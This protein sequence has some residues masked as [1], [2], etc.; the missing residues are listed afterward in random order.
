M[1]EKDRQT[2]IEE[3][4]A[5]LDDLE[6]QLKQSGEDVKGTYQEKKKRIANILRQYAKQ[7]EEAGSDRLKEIGEDSKELIGLLEADYNL[8]YTDYVEETGKISN[9]VDALK[10]KIKKVGGEAE[11]LKGQLSGDISETLEKFKTELDIQKAHFKATKERTLKEY[12]EWKKNR[13]EEV[14][15]LKERLEKEMAGSKLEAFTD[16]LSKSYDHLRQAFKKLW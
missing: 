6:E 12:E 13:L 2:L 5:E 4:K 1:E 8:S 9:A 11:K 16:E 10:G 7:L 15:A 14:A 3:I